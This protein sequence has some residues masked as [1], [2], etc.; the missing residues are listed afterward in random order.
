MPLEDAMRT[1]RSIR[2]LKSDPVDDSLVL[3]L[4]ELAMK[5]PTGSNAQ[6]WEFIVVKDREV[7][8]KLG[9]LNRRAMQLFGP[10]YR[11]SIARRGDEKML[12][13]QKAVQWQ[14]DHFEEIPVVVVACLRGVIA[15]WPRISTSSAYGSIYPAVQNLLLA[16]R[17]AGLGAGLITV[18]LWSTVLARRALGLPWNVTPCA[19]VPLGWP[20]GKYGPTTRRPVAEIVSL[21]RYGNRA[22]R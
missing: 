19:V 9:R 4:L 2:R 1:Q 16:A 6:N 18:P 8:A 17:A 13:L 10:I 5:A 14:A 3:H 7:V 20:I 21:D 11:R 15:P 12:R 22:F